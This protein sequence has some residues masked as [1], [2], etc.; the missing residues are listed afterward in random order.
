MRS[1]FVPNIISVLV[2]LTFSLEKMIDRSQ[3]VLQARDMGQLADTKW[4]LLTPWTFLRC[5]DTFSLVR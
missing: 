4:A 2:L 3:K 5:R 1:G